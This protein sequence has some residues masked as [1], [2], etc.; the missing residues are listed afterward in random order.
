MTTG[1]VSFLGGIRQ[2]YLRLCQ[3]VTLAHYQFGPRGPDEVRRS[4]A[5]VKVVA[6]MLDP[7]LAGER[8]GRWNPR[9]L[10]WE[11]L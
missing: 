8:S 4:G 6:K 1:L 5:A 7:V 9:K 3:N 10:A 2:L 11:L